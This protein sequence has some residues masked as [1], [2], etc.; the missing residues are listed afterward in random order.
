M[1][2]LPVALS[3]TLPGADQAADRL[4]R[5]RHRNPS[6]TV[7]DRVGGAGQCQGAGR[8][9]SSSTRVW[10]WAA[11]PYGH[12]RGADAAPPSHAA[13]PPDYGQAAQRARAPLLRGRDRHPCD[14]KT[15]ERALGAVETHRHQRPTAVRRRLPLPMLAAEIPAPPG[16]ELAAAM[17]GA[18]C[19]RRRWHG[20]PH[21]AGPPRVVVDV[22]KLFLYV[23]Y[24]NLPCC[25]FFISVLHHATDVATVVVL[26]FIC[27]FF[28]L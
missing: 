4:I 22:S 26:S 7:A 8:R 9:R 24:V 2:T 3:V 20:L 5:Q 13:G 21:G 10:A 19:G 16:V 14:Q 28:M 11:A 25:N 12:E 15:G 17:D 6:A 18:P 1:L 27:C 23:S